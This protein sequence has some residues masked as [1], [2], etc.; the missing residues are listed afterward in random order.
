MNILFKFI[1]K[2]L[3]RFQIYRYSNGHWCLD[4]KNILE[5]GW[6]RRGSFQTR[7]GA[8]FQILKIKFQETRKQKVYYLK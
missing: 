8:F 5:P 7:F 2:E 3:A 1:D 6:E 4:E